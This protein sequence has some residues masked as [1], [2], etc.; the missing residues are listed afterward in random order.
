MMN[1]AVLQNM[2]NEYGDRIYAF[3]LNNN[4]YL[5]IGYNS[6]SSPL[7]K[8]IELVT[9]EDVDFIKVHHKE[10]SS[11]KPAVNYVEF[12]PTEHIEMVGIMDEDSA[13]Y[14]VD[15]LTFR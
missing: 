15:P 2:I 14:R 11:T 8:D 10:I 3:A 9:I 4:K 13:N 7:L 1:N 6:K 12:I 5:L